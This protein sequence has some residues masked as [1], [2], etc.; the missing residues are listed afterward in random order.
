MEP[1]R[2]SCLIFLKTVRCRHFAWT[3]F[4]VSFLIF[5][6]FMFQCVQAVVLPGLTLQSLFYFEMLSIVLSKIQQ[7]PG[8][9]RRV[10]QLKHSDSFFV[11][12]F[13]GWG[14]A[15]QRRDPSKAVVLSGLTLVSVLFRNIKHCSKQDTGRCSDRNTVIVFVC[16]ID[17]VCFVFV[18]L[19]LGVVGG[20]VS[21]QLYSLA[22]LKFQISQ[23]KTG[24][25]SDR[26]IEILFFFK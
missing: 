11:F 19:F 14:G 1:V 8:V 13:R 22:L 25:Y 10:Q 7:I 18:F 6:F 4:L 3:K 23:R 26:N 17:F 21:R 16:F 9:D 5:R 15:L 12:F 2:H 24:G 20:V